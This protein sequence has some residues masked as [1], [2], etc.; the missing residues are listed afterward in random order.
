M[1][2]VEMKRMELL[3][4]QKDKRPLL[5]TMQRLECIQVSELG[6]GDRAFGRSS[7]AAELPR[8]DETIQRVQWAIQKLSKYDGYKP[9]LLGAK[10]EITAEAAAD[11]R[12]RE[13]ELLKTVEALEALERETGELRGQS[14]RLSALREQLAPWQGFEENVGVL[15]GTRNTVAMLGTVQKTALEAMQSEGRLPALCCVSV[16]GMQRDQACVYVVAHRACWEQALAVLKEGGFAQATL[17]G[18]TDTVAE[19][20]K[21][22]E[23]EQADI[24][25]KQAK[26]QEQFAQH[27]EAGSDLRVL[28]DLL[29]NDAERLRAESGFSLSG[30][31]FF[32][33]GWVPA[34]M[35]ER[36]EKALVETAPTA[37]MEFL[38]P[39]EGDEPPVLLHN[40]AVATPFESVVAGYSLPA[41]GGYDPT[42]VMAPFFCCFFGMMV[43]DAGY[44]LMMALLIPILIKVM[45]PSK[46]T[47]RL[48]WM[49]CMGGV[50]TLFWGAMYNT[51]F[52]FSPWPSLFDPINNSMPVMAVCIGL[53]A[54]HLFTGLGVG[55][56][57]NIRNGKPWDAVFDQLSWFLLIV[58][59]GMLILPATAAIGKWMAI[60]G[61]GI[62]L[63]TAGRAKSKNPLKRLVSGLGA[64]Y[65]ITSWVSDLLSYMRLF[66]MGLATGVI[67][68]VVNILV[69]MVFSSGPI[70]WVLGAVIFVFAHLF[71]AAINILGAYVHS[72]RLQYIEFFGKFYEDGGKPF[73]PLSSVNRYVSVKTAAQD[74]A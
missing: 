24:A 13:P 56:Y 1:A 12:A 34:P 58:G 16:V 46:P 37:C 49:L 63:L 69:G 28:C 50:M 54:L 64:L 27:A 74:R 32:L 66:G 17:P 36:V 43:S 3:A 14:A 33:K 11:V 45:K 29:R 68:M 31:T 48:M 57:V 70:G 61:A 59:L 51:W 38:D 73:K 8:M 44:G 4:L 72:C 62:I 15:Q 6:K 47:T 5:Q 60:A 71:N 42:A 10:P 25:D 41:P 65:G 22:Q 40:N 39:E 67:G 35:C 30:K 19:T 7:A 21:R 2:I 55:A 18:V 26:V 20:L 53:G 9:M 23:C 52:G